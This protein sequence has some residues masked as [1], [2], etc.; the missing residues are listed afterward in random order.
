[1]LEGQIT[2]IF[3][4]ISRLTQSM[5]KVW[6]I[7]KQT[8]RQK[9]NIILDS[10]ANSVDVASDSFTL[11]SGHTIGSLRF[12]DIRTGEKNGEIKST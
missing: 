12:W 4:S 7:S 1:M 2:K 11:V 3:A 8:Y 5:I 6:D 9:T 10:T